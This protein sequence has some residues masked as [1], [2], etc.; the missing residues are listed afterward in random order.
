MVSTVWTTCVSYIKTSLTYSHHGPQRPMY[1]AFDG[2]EGNPF[3]LTL[4]SLF[5][6]LTLTLAG[7]GS[8][9]PWKCEG[10]VRENEC[11]SRGFSPLSIRLC[12]GWCEEVRV[13]LK[14]SFFQPSGPS[15]SP[16]PRATICIL[17]P[18]WVRRLQTVSPKA[19]DSRSAGTD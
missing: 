14:Y 10:D 4:P 15:R 9:Q 6:T 16:K 3:T 2:R 19:S 18:L 5:W 1:R 12:E 17:F 11:P 13:V 8:V 7:N